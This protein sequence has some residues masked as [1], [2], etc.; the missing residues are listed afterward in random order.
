MYL[1]NGVRA[2]LARDTGQVPAS[3]HSVDA[4]AAA[5][6]GGVSLDRLLGAV[7]DSSSDGFG[8]GRAAN[9]RP[10]RKFETGLGII[11]FRGFRS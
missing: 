8:L 7:V 6:Q 3:F 10:S 1:I 11:E 2:K 5:L 9:S 4:L